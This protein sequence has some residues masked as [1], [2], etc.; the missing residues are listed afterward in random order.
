MEFN[1]WA[2]QARAK[3]DFIFKVDNNKYHCTCVVKF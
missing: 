1:N 2:Q 3:T